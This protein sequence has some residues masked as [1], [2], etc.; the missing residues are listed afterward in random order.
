MTGLRFPATTSAIFSFSWWNCVYGRAVM[1]WGQCKRAFE[2][3]SQS[4]HL[5]IHTHHEP[6]RVFVGGQNAHRQPM[7]QHVRLK[8]LD[9]DGL[10]RAPLDDEVLT[11]RG[12]NGEISQR[13]SARTAQT[14]A[15][16]LGDQP[17][18]RGGR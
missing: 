11:I 2:R 9:E 17:G 1:G 13:V 16:R 10:V 5:S 7:S 8:E 18:E 15:S 14:Q 6:P 12:M 3:P 4:I